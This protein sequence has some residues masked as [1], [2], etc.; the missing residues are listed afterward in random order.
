VRH[1]WTRIDLALRW[2]DAAGGAT[3]DYGASGERQT[4]QLVLDYYL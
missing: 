3:T 2:Q 1:H 4:W